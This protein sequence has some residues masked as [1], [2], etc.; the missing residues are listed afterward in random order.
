MNPEE[1]KRSLAAAAA[2]LDQVM[3]EDLAPLAN[4][5]LAA[6]LEHA[7]FAGGKRI[8]P[9]LTIQAARLVR[10]AT[11]KETPP[12][13]PAESGDLD[14][15]A[16]SFEYLH[17]ASLLHDDVIDLAEQRRGRPTVNL[18]WD[19][20]TAILAGDFLHAR[21]MLLAGLA[22]GVACLGLIG[23][24]TQAMVAAEFLQQEAASSRDWR[25]E[26]Y[27]AVLEGKTAALIAAA[28][29]SGATA[30]GGDPAQCKAVRTYG[31]NLGLAFQIIDDLLDYLGD[32]AATGK[33]TGNDL[34]EGKMTLPLLLARQGATAAQKE[35]LERILLADPASRRSRFD[36]VRDLLEQTGAFAA[37]RTRAEKLIA[38]GTA[39]LEIFPATAD[40]NLLTALGQYVL[41]RKK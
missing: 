34:Q 17:A 33:A 11:D 5:K 25:Q 24:A 14:R 9:L 21:A 6:V 22:G 30:A 26:T 28:C 1:L 10:A 29:E 3:R 36:R 39:A 2:R 35:E 12:A 41:S 8:R 4:R 18:R 32:P 27:F 23:S 37:C 20:G 38:A 16:I 13:P 31:A 15:L 7:L 40:R 19:D